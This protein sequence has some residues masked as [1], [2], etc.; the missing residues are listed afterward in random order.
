M[1]TSPAPC[2]TPVGCNKDVAEV[3]FTITDPDLL[4]NYDNYNL[5][6]IGQF[7]NYGP[8]NII[9]GINII[10]PYFIKIN[11]TYEISCFFVKLNP[12]SSK[13]VLFKTTVNKC[14]M[15]IDIK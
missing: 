5:Q 14:Y 9:N 6:L 2:P 8:Y 7:I 1:L 15:I 3:Y 13:R 4:T 12:Y 10:G 11:T